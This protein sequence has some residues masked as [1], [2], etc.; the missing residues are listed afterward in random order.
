MRQGFT[1]A[2]LLIVVAMLS[3]LMVSIS[4]LLRGNQ[5]QAMLS[6]QADIVRQSF[7]ETVMKAKTGAVETGATQLPV[8]GFLISK[9]TKEI[10]PLTLQTLSFEDAQSMG[11]TAILAQST[12]G[13][14]LLQ[15]DAGKVVN[16][17]LST[18]ETIEADGQ[19]VA[20]LLLLFE[21]VSNTVATWLNSTKQGTPLQNVDVT[22]QHADSNKMRR[23]LRIQ[24][25]TGTIIPL[26]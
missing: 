10:V 18:I 12:R 8:R 3:L 4:P 19:Q 1:L 24:P 25:E 5:D 26:P 9:D 20:T 21:P 23:T 2:E 14:N 13:G 11:T 15:N 16:R 6:R 22:I 7:Y 17:P